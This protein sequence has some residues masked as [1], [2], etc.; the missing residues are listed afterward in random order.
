MVDPTGRNYARIEQYFLQEVDKRD[1]TV[2]ELDLA[3][4]EAYRGKGEYNG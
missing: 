2:N 1:M 4:W 3:V